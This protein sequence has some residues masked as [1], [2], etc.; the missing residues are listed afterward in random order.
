MGRRFS[1]SILTIASVRSRTIRCFCSG[2]KT[3]SIAFTL[4]SGM[5][6]S[7]LSDRPAAG[8]EVSVATRRVHQRVHGL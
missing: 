8:H 4:T 3:P 7:S 6:T 5:S 1:P 2:L